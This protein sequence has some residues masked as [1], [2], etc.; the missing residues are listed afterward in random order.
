[1]KYEFDTEKHK[2]EDAAKMIEQISRLYPTFIYDD[3]DEE[4][5]ICQVLVFNRKRKGQNHSIALTVTRYEN[6]ISLRNE[7]RADEELPY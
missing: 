6:P 4:Y 1:M 3:E 5:E 7:N 2:I